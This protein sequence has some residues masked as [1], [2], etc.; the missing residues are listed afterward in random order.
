ML[1]EATSVKKKDV[2]WLFVNHLN[3]FR[4]V[5]HYKAP[6]KVKT[7]EMVEH[8][9]EYLNIYHGSSKYRTYYTGDVNKPVFYYDYEKVEIDPERITDTD[10]FKPVLIGTLIPVE[11]LNP[12]YYDMTFNTPPIKIDSINFNV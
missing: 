10:Y 3:E 8:H 5:W 6:V 4:Y 11:L 7:Y 2:L 9:N 12:V 1:L